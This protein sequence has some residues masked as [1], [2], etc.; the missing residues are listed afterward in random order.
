MIV[1]GESGIVLY[2]DEADDFHLGSLLDGPTTDW[3]ECVAVSPSL[4]VAAGDNGAIYTSTNGVAWKRQNSGTTSWLRGAAFG[5][6]AFVAVGESG[7]IYRSLDGTNWNK[8]SSPTTQDLNRVRFTLGR[9][10]AVGEGGV[11]L[12]STNAGLNWFHESSGATN[13]LQYVVASGLDRLIDGAYEVRLQQDGIWSNELAKTNGP[14]DWSYYTAI[15]L[16]NFFLIAGQSGLQSEG[17]QTNEATYFWLTPYD[18][19]RSWLW[20]VKRLPGF[21]VTVGDYGTVLTSGQGVDW[22]L[23]VVPPAV[24]NTTLLGVGGTTNLLIAVGSGGAMLHSPNILTNI[25]VTNGTE[26]STQI[27]STLGIKWHTVPSPTTNEL[28]GVATLSNS[29]HVITGGKGSLFTSPDGT[30]WI[31][32]ASGTTNLLTSVTEWPGG[33]VAC[34]HRGTLITS[35]NGESWSMQPSGTTNWLFRV[36]YLNQTLIAVGQNGTILT[37]ANGTDWS[38]RTSG[39]TAWLTDAEFIEDT[40]FVV[41]YSGTVLSSTNLIHWIARGTLTTKPLYAAATDARQLVVVGVEGAIL[42]SQVVP[43]TNAVTVLEY[44]RVGTNSNSAWNVFLFGGSPDQRFTLDRNTNL[45]ATQWV[46]GSQL[47][48]LDG[49]GTLYYAEQ[50]TGTNIPAAEFYRATVVP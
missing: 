43:N 3:L 7:V 39:T 50:L 1:T 17:Y 45:L 26:V 18:S 30:N 38:N 37:S 20:D 33:L 25:V 14:P 24:A 28:Q 11:T 29:F 36:R 8:R 44:D 40:W 31:P 9:F 48:I 22:T 34:G 2:A 13:S 16:P 35:A 23:E 46:S 32:R 49:S 12:S 15:G 4:L 42:R 10:T 47:E 19:V 41:G 6:G 5:A 21:Y 27:V